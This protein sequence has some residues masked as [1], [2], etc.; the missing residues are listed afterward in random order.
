[1]GDVNP[2]GGFRDEPRVDCPLRVTLCH[3]PPDDPARAETID[4]SHEEVPGHLAHGDLPRACPYDC[5]RGPSPV[6]ETGQ[7]TCYEPGDD[8]DHQCCVSVDPRFTDNLDGTVTDNL[9]GLIWLQD[10]NCFGLRDWTTALFDVTILAEGSCGLADG[11]AAGDWRLP[12][13]RE[14]S[15]LIDYDLYGPALPEDRPFWR[16]ACSCCWSSATHKNMAFKAWRVL[17]GYGNVSFDEKS[18]HHFV[19]PVRAGS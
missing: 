6:P 10:A 9:T 12:N 5:N 14:L 3:I 13:V 8:G 7:R 11:S 4:V 19:R 16:V 18:D 15:S 2:A 17:V 1:M